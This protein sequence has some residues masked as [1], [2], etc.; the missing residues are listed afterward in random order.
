M[1]NN[2][3]IYLAPSIIFRVKANTIQSLCQY[4]YLSSFY[5]DHYYLALTPLKGYKL[6]QLFKNAS[7]LKFIPKGILNINL[8]NFFY[9][10]T[11]NSFYQLINCLTIFLKLKVSNPK[12]SLYI[13]SRSTIASYFLS[14]FNIRHV[15]EVHNLEKNRLIDF[16]QK[17]ILE[18]QNVNK[19]FISS[20]LKKLALSKNNNK[21]LGRLIVAPD[22]SPS[23]SSIDFAEV[24]I[25]KKVREFLFDENSL[26]CIYA[27]SSGD[28]RGIE[29][30]LTIA[31]RL[32]NIKFIF[33]GEIKLKLENN[34]P[35]NILV[36]GNKSHLEALYIMSLSDLGLMPYQRNLSMGRFSLN[37]LEWMSPLKMFDYMNS[38]LLILAS[39]H[40]VLEEVLENNYSCIFIQNYDNPDAWIQNIKKIK[41]SHINRIGLNA[42]K[43]FNSK[44]TYDNRTKIILENLIAV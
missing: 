16:M 44:Y 12:N 21:T 20:K 17:V 43:I 13:Y 39:Y 33:M 26:K 1:K 22:S 31:R 37:S 32:P 35:S 2:Y 5:K 3:L 6:T 15:F 10:E 36:L 41:K 23:Y 38:R 25:N 14:V 4:K 29:L 19:V 7:N 24:N 8:P 40:D 30:L 11:F 34:F 28:G 27:G 18:T 42:K 9:R